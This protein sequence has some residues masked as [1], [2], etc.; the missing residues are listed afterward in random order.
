MGK[1]SGKVRV[2]QV[3]GGG[4]GANANVL[5]NLMKPPDLKEDFILPPT[6]GDPN[7][8]IPWP[9]SSGAYPKKI[10]CFVGNMEKRKEFYI[11]FVSQ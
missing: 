5:A 6:R 9:N 4:G 10:V 8:S 1:K 7:V 11:W 2:K 3:G